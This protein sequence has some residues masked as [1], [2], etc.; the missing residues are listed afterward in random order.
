[1]YQLSV[2]HTG[3]R[4]CTI[5]N[6]L[7][8]YFHPMDS[9]VDFSTGTYSHQCK[10]IRPRQRIHLM[11]TFGE[12][13]KVLILQLNPRYYSWSAEME[14]MNVC[15]VRN[16]NIAPAVLEIDLSRYFNVNHENDDNTNV[17]AHLTGYISRL[18]YE[19]TDEGMTG[20]HFVSVTKSS[21]TGDF[22]YSDDLRPQEPQNLG[23]KP[24]YTWVPPYILF[25]RISSTQLQ[26]WPKVYVHEDDD[27]RV[28]VE[29]EEEKTIKVETVD[30]ESDTKPIA[31]K[32]KR[33]GKRKTQINQKVLFLPVFTT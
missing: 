21:V 10:N 18:G 32:T 9:D 29:F 22:Y 6:C 17:V 1:M 24:N 15:E 12:M 20:G 23:P 19:D 8:E 31:Q 27:T 3:V 30:S 16:V 4:G 33:S 25:Y 14:R 28:T 2:N 11:D 26:L 5:K 13:E 7:D